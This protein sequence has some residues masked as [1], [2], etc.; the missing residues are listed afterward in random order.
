MATKYDYGDMVVALLDNLA[1]LIGTSEEGGAEEYLGYQQ[2]LVDAMSNADY[3]KSAQAMGDDTYA[4]VH[5]LRPELGEP[6]PAGVGKL[7]THVFDPDVQQPPQLGGTDTVSGNYAANQA[8][9]N[10]HVGGDD[11][12]RVP[13]DRPAGI[14]TAPAAGEEAQ[15]QDRR[16]ILRNAGAGGPVGLD[17]GRVI[18]RRARRRRH[19][20]GHPGHLDAAD[21]HRIERSGARKPGRLRRLHGP[22]GEAQGRTQTRTTTRRSRPST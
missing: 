15:Q 22:D 18:N 1:R 17:N 11:F 20:G 10:E 4:P 5:F 12:A 7:N 14:G 19:L 16:G 3:H 6:P 13:E 21:A 2:R 8:G 9:I